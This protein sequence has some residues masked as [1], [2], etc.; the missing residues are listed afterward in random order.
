M[1]KS[2]KILIPVKVYE[3]ETMVANGNELSKQ[4]QVVAV[5]KK[6]Y[7]N[8]KETQQVV[9]NTMLQMYGAKKYKQKYKLGVKV[10]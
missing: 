6:I 4:F 5:P 10:W 8:K 3:K 9:R 2:I 7:V 1:A